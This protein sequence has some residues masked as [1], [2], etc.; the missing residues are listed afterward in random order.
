MGNERNNNSSLDAEAPLIQVYSG[1]AGSSSHGSAYQQVALS[2]TTITPNFTNAEG[3]VAV[4]FPS[5][6]PESSATALIGLGGLALIL[7]RHK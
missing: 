3:V 1:D 4:E 5:V 7:Y 6:V 2:R